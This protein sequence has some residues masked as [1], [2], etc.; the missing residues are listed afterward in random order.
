MIV[1][2]LRRAIRTVP[3]L[4]G[5]SVLVFASIR[6]IP[7]DPALIFAGD[8]AT[9]ELVAQTRRELGL[10]RPLWAQYAIFLRRAVMGD[11]GTSTRTG[12]P[13]AGEL[14]HR[15]RMTLLLAGAAI[16]FSVTVGVPLGIVAAV[17]RGRG[18]DKASVAVAL[19]GVSLPTFLLGVLLQLVLA[20]RLGWFPVAGAQSWQH[21]VLPAIS[22]GAFPVAH[23]TRLLR[24]SL[25]ETLGEDYTRTA[26]A[27][28]LPESAVVLRHALKPAL[29]PAVTIVGLQFGAMLGAS[30]FAEAVFTWP[31][32]G[33]YLVQ[34]IA[35]RDYP[36][37][38][39]AVLLLAATYVTANLAVDLVYAWLDPRTR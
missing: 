20:V 21:L 23:I 11:L 32:I 10:D 27:K 1:V 26:R 16:A 35:F 28:G 29:I 8:H 5:A 15:Y 34:A 18:P 3:V 19:L 36:V 24:T 7:G 2:I 38:Q 9:P 14:M 39:G 33:R 13:V 12:R 6:L 31:G 22:L 4:L 25:L 30:V 17:R 37:V